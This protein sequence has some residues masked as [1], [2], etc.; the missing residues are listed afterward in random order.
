MKSYY[1]PKEYKLDKRIYSLTIKRIQ[2]YGFYKD[3]IKRLSEKAKTAGLSEKELREKGF[4][5]IYVEAI[6]TALKNYVLDEFQKAIKEHVI[7]GASYEYLER[8]YFLTKP[9]LKRWTRKFV[10][11]VAQELE[12]F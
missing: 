4:S 5:Q 12:D 3:N 1:Q 2:S 7:Y 9:S 6:D 10:W 11:A 8:K